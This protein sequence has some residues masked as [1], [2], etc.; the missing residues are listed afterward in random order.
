[1]EKEMNKNYLTTSPVFKLFSTA[2]ICT[3]A[4]LRIRNKYKAISNINAEISKK[5]ELLDNN[6]SQNAR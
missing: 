4:V 1:M 5:Q 6:E 3:V 2:M